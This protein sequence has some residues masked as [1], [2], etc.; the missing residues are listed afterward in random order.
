M[1]NPFW[2][3]RRN[4]EAATAQVLAAV[5]LGDEA[6]MREQ[7]IRREHDNR[8]RRIA[9][10]VSSLFLLASLVAS[11]VLF[12]T[13]TTP[14]PPHRDPGR[15]G[16]AVVNEEDRDRPLD[17]SVRYEGTGKSTGFSI[18]VS[19]WTSDARRPVQVAVYLC[20]PLRDGLRLSEANSPGDLAIQTVPG[21]PIEFDTFLGRHEDC[22]YAVATGNLAQVIIDGQSSHEFRSEASARVAFAAPGV[23]TI[24]TEEQLGNYRALPISRESRVNVVL[25]TP[26]DLV[27][28]T[29]RPQIPPSGHPSWTQPVVSDGPLPLDY[30][31]SGSLQGREYAS[32][33]QLFVAGASAGLAGAALMWL[34]QL[35]IDLIRVRGQNVEEASVAEFVAPPR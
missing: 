18:V 19:D 29:A 11:I 1:L 30:F 20:G 15:I 34:A 4:F 16:I 12:G 17:V 23:S 26:A 3:T 8:R 32:Q 33:W 9:T 28:G 7:A 13:A 35:V 5:T 10:L 14:L 6:R 25:N 24:L 31:V 27:I 2:V 22:S 21:S